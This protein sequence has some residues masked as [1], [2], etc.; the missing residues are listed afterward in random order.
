MLTLPIAIVPI[1][2]PFAMLFTNPTWRKA[3]LLLVGAILATGQR[4]VA[5]ALRVMG[6]SND[7]NSARYHHVLNRADWSPLESSQI[8]LRLLLQ[9]LDRGD[10]PLVFGIDETLERP[11]GSTDQRPGGLPR[12]S[13]LQ[14]E[15]H[16]QSQSARGGRWVSLIWLGQIPW[17]AVATGPCLFS[18]CWRLRNAIT[19]RWD[20]GTIRH[21]RTRLGP[22]DD[23]VSL[24]WTPMAASPTPGDGG[25]SASGGL[26]LLHFCQSVREPVTLIA[27]L[28]LD[29]GLYDPAQPRPPG[30]TGR[31]RV[32]GSR[33]PTLKQLLV[34]PPILK[35]A[36]SP[37]WS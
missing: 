5:A 1:L 23:R 20:A 9:H 6:L 36:K 25:R 10:G 7:R 24:R 22:P 27:R 34:S 2:A 32:K 16:R 21:R 13:A 17:A 35:C 18:P 15:L 26:D 28:R 33:Q 3:Q 8:L 12:S 11:P 37:K 4:T 14:S 30:Q 19:K 31:P 29:A